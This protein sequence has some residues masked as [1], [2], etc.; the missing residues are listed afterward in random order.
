MQVRFY[1]PILFIIFHNTLFA[2]SIPGIVTDIMGKPLVGA[3][4]I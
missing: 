2:Q 4:I 1:L 3:N